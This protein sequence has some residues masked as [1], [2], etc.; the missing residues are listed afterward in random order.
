LSGGDAAALELINRALMDIERA[1][2]DPA[3]LERRPW[4]RHQLYAPAFTYAPEV[5]PLLSEAID[6]RDPI[7]VAEA[8][9]R[10]AAAL[11]RAARALAPSGTEGS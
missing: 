1:F 4:Y 2:T 7:R 5:L 11:D 6:A 8:E 3:G 10:L 9:R